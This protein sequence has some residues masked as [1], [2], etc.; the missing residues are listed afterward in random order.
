M[1]REV[2]AACDAAVEGGA[3]DILVKD[4]HDSARNIDPSNLPEAAR[5]F[6]GWDSSPLSMMA[7]LDSSFDGVVFTGYHS[8]AGSDGNPLSHTMNLGVQ[9]MK[10]NGEYTSEFVINSYTAGYF[11]VPVLFLSGDRQLCESAGRLNKNIKTVAVSEGH[12]SGSISINPDLAVERIR[13]GVFAALDDDRS[14]YSIK[15][16]EGFNVEVCFKEHPPAC[17]GGYY[18][19]AVRIGPKTVSFESENYMDVLK[20][21]FF[22][23]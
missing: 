7:G 22:V 20:F 18:P 23:L 5:L 6:R 12:G 17:R 10:I 14:K 9:Y 1:T 2:R 15:L 19:G 13:K 16:P 3:D 11:G 4:A 21:L 8:A